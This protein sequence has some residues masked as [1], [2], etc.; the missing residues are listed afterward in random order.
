M[1]MISKFKSVYVFEA[2]DDEIIGQERKKLSQLPFK[3][4]EVIDGAKHNLSGRALT[5]FFT[6]LDLIL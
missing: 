5:D 4:Y 1:K 2:G 3:S 6:K